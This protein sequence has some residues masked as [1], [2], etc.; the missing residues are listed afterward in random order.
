[1]RM[2]LRTIFIPALLPALLGLAACGNHGPRKPTADELLNGDPLPLA[3]GAKWTYNATISVYDA[4]Q[5]KEIERSMSWT[6]EVTGAR[7]VGDG[8]V[9][10]DIKGWPSDLAAA[11]GETPLPS[12]QTLIRSGN[13]FLWA[14]PSDAMGTT[15]AP[16]TLDGAKGW[17]T[18]PLRDGQR[19]CPSPDDVYCWQAE[20]TDEGTRLRF[21]TGPDDEDYL[22]QP[23]TGVARY[24][25]E[26]HGT[27]NTVTAVLVDYKP[28]KAPA[29]A[30]P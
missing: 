21:R 1:M 8:V 12:T 4:E 9:A 5:D 18:W 23:G 20:T 6:T 2:S 15:T 25:Y 28:G 14:A 17:F 30:T 27:T 19:V 13:S 26:H 7:P 11:W 24:T 10:Y 22:L 16:V 29:T 3:V